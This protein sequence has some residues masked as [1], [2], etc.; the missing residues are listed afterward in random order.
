MRS[1]LGVAGD[2]AST[3]AKAYPVCSA[4][5]LMGMDILIVIAFLVGNGVF[6]GAEIAILSVR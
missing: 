5:A 1:P 4:P 2:P 3:R 6:A